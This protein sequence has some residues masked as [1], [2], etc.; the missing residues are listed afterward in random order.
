MIHNLTKMILIFLLIFNFI[1]ESADAVNWDSVYQTGTS[2][3]EGDPREDGIYGYKYDF[4]HSG[5]VSTDNAAIF[6]VENG[7]IL[8]NLEKGQEV[9]IIGRK[10][11]GALI[12]KE[13]D[14]EEIGPYIELFKIELEDQTVALVKAVDVAREDKTFHSPDAQIL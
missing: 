1:P 3:P 14:S 13:P 8:G 9:K 4:P 7:E 6:N 2:L 12:G 11:E 5:I 10:D